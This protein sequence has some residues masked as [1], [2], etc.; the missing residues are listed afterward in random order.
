MHEPLVLMLF[1]VFGAHMSVEKFQYSDVNWREMSGFKAYLVAESGGVTRANCH[2]SF[3]ADDGQFAR[4]KLSVCRV[5]RKCAICTII[6]K[7]K[8]ESFCSSLNFLYLC[9]LKG[10]KEG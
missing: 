1:P 10:E 9:G 3:L 8:R 4:R 7:E 6:M 2:I 5:Q